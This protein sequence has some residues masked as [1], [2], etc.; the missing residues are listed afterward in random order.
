MI[1]SKEDA[2]KLGVKLYSLQKIGSNF[3][4][5]FEKAILYPFFIRDFRENLRKII[6]KKARKEGA[7]LAVITNQTEGFTSFREY[8]IYNYS[9]YKY[10]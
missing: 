2:G 4:T 7:D 5:H 3:N 8:V 6:E 1:M 9:L 10:K